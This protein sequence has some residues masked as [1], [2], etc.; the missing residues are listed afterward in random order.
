MT[1]RCCAPGCGS[2]AAPSRPP[3]RRASLR[4]IQKKDCTN[5]TDDM[6]KQNDMLTKAGCKFSP[7]VRAGNTYTFSATC[8]MQGASGTSKSVLTVQGDG[9]FEIR[10]ESDFGGKKTHE[11]LRAKRTGDCPR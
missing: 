11:V 10:V 7:V 9:A 8:T 2:S 3:A 6:K 4:T 1:G 5:P